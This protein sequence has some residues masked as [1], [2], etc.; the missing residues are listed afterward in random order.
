[1]K[2]STVPTL[3]NT[4]F[5]RRGRY[6]EEADYLQCKLCDIGFTGNKTL[7]L[8]KAMLELYNDAY[9]HEYGTHLTHM[10]GLLNRRIK[11]IMGCE[12]GCLKRYYTDEVFLEN[13]MDDV[14]L[15]CRGKKLRYSINGVFISVNR[16]EFS[17]KTQFAGSTMVTFGLVR[18]LKKY[19][20]G[21]T[22]LDN[23]RR[24]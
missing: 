19:L 9:T 13:C 5:N 20:K 10:G 12:F 23:M 2:Q 24:F 14:I 22:C 15:K 1:M 4:Y 16:C 8:Y 11:P 18:D 3:D 7:D 17:M 6:Q 21:Y